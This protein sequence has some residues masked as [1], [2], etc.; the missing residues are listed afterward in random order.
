MRERS[1]YNPKTGKFFGFCSTYLPAVISYRKDLWDAV[2]IVPDS[3]EQI[4]LGGRRIK[5][6]RERPV[7]FS[8]NSED[9]A[10]STMRTIMYS[11][12]SSEQDEAGSPGLKS[13]ATLEVIKYVKALYQGAM[14]KEVLTWEPPS[15]NRFMLNG[16]GC[17]TLDTISIPRASEALR[18]PFAND[19]RLLTGCGK[20]V[21]A[22]PR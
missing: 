3:W 15:N 14:T 17:L 20:R 6:L 13:K 22:C 12:G 18:L 5:L 16:E 1:T 9:N 7:G 11:S 8:L 19:L 10:Q 2:G 4:L 21:C